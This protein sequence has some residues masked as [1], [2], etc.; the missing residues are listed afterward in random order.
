M[1][2][3]G[4]HRARPIRRGFTLLEVLLASAIGILL[5]AGVYSAL[6]VVLLQT[7]TA[8]ETAAEAELT[9]AIGNRLSLDLS[10]SLG[11]MP[12]RSGGGVPTSTST[13]P[14]TSSSSSSTSSTTS[15]STSGTSSSS[16]SSTSGT[17]SSSSGGEEDV[18]DTTDPDA[19]TELAADVPFQAGVIGTDRQ[20]SLFSSR[21]P[22]WMSDRT[23]AADSTMQLPADLRRVTYYIGSSGGLCR[24][25]RPWVT[26]DG[27]RNSADP[28]RST[29]ATDLIAPEVVD[30]IFEYLDGGTWQSSYDG[31]QATADATSVMGPPRAI[32][33][34][35]TFASGKQMQQ[36]FAVR[37][38]NGL[39]A[40]A[41]TTDSTTD[42][43]S[44][45]S[46]SSGG[47]T[48]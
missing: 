10:A 42:M 29:E 25:E 6:D 11:A 32:R 40:P 9:R 14:S 35:L 16:T 3:R 31:S 5:L 8:R 36:V 34:T 26:A 27:V 19:D 20:L 48:P 2:R 22:Q 44:S 23:V 7:H 18:T 37:A 12:P 21:V 39:Y 43:T 1:I 24:Q 41:A 4:N 15:S 47:T 33:V 28:D 45:S 46:S 30:V 13:M 17:T 38:A